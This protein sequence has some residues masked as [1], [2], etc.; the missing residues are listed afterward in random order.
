MRESKNKRESERAQTILYF[1]AGLSAK[2]ISVVQRLDLG[3]GPIC[4]SKNAG[5]GMLL[6]YSDLTSQG[7][8]H[9]LF[10]EIRDQV[11]PSHSRSFLRDSGDS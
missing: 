2:E 6:K 10:A 7:P 4:E 9:R 8:D 11:G 1:A 3:R 5:A